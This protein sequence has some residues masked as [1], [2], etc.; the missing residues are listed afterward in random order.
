MLSFMLSVFTDN[1]GTVA[2]LAVLVAI[3]ALIVVK[4]RR[5]KKSGKS[6]CG[7]GC[8]GCPMSGKCHAASIA[9]KDSTEAENSNTP[10]RA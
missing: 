5:D 9:A 4:M 7:G 1:I 2:V 8:A 6:S 3:V 10:P